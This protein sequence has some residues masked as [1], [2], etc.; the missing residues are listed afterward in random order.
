VT[1]QFVIPCDADRA[2]FDEIVRF[3]DAHRPWI[4]MSNFTVATPLPGT[5]LYIDALKSMPE[6]ADRIA[7][8]HDAFSLFTALLPMKLEAREFYEQVARVFRAA[9]QVWL[10]ALRSPWLLRRMMKAPRAFKALTDPETFL[11]VHR[12]VQGDRLLVGA[13]IRPDADGDA[14][15]ADQVA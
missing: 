2:Y 15:P 12:Q 11:D 14:Q 3:L 4:R 7:V 1:A 10:M 8:S 9:N 13:S 5:D 6:L